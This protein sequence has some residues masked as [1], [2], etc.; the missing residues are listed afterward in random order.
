MVDWGFIRRVGEAD[1][2]T[3]REAEEKLADKDEEIEELNDTIN[4]R[5]GPC[6]DCRHCPQA[7]KCDIYE[8]RSKVLEEKEALIARLKEEWIEERMVAIFNDE[9]FP[10]DG[11][12]DLAEQVARRQ[13]EKE[14][15]EPDPSTTDPRQKYVDSVRD[16][17]KDAPAPVE[18]LCPDCAKRPKVQIVKCP[19]CGRK[20]A[21]PPDVAQPTTK[22]KKSEE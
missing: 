7:E 1:M 18:R 16:A 5:G 12:W 11:D 20:A 2:V 4:Q 22:K 3:V 13:I 10:E 15:K 6:P 19:R 17:I 8:P 21:F 14:L 9:T